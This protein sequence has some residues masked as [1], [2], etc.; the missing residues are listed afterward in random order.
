MLKFGYQLGQG[1]GAIG[2]GKATLVEL[3]NNKWGFSLGYEPFNEELFQAFRGKKRKYIGQWMSIPH[4]KV[5]FPA[6]AEVI[7]SEVA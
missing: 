3:S 7:R 5:T 6:P 2:H 1:L 4:I